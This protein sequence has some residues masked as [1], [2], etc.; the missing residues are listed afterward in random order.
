MEEEIYKQTLNFIADKLEEI[1]KLIRN[2]TAEKKQAPELRGYFLIYFINILLH[3]SLTFYKLY[4]TTI[5]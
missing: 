5:S 2:L 3:F 1:A 4:V